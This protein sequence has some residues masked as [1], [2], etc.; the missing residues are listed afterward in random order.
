MPI[1]H[2]RID[3]IEFHATDIP[4]TKKFY[5]DV[6]GWK[7]TDYGPDY[8]AFEDGRLTGGFEK[9]ESVSNG[10]P[11]VILFSSQLEKTKADVL[12]HGGRISKDIFAFP[13]GRRFHFLDPNGNEL[14]VW[15]DK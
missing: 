12:T 6:F 3:Y 4:A 8:V 9:S 7:F 10:G 13:G 11:L 1:Q 2:N 14:A 15:S 5:A